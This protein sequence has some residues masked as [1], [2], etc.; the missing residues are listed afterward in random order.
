MIIIRQILDGLFLGL[1]AISGTYANAASLA[2]TITEIRV[3]IVAI[4]TFQ[5]TRRP[6]NEFRGTGFAVGDGKHIITNAH[7]IPDI[8]NTDQK[9]ILA[10]F[11]GSEIN[12]EVRSAAIVDMDIEHDLTLLKIDGKPLPSLQLGNSQRVR[13][14]EAV[15][16]TGFPIGMVL[17][18]YPITHR[19]IV[20]ALTPI[21]I[22][23]MSSRQLDA[24]TIKR[25]RKPYKVLQLDA[26]A[27]PGNS[28]S[29]VYDPASGRVIGIINKV[30]VK[31][32]KENLLTQPSGITYAIPSQYIRELLN[33]KGMGD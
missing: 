1:L 27:Y 31:E 33:R 12:I 23:A 29:P 2:D 32:S 13:E 10:V 3:S 20:S 8:L 25:L 17:G 18:L 15:A 24:T 16:F 21:A 22:P 9:E 28:G 19:G 11:A 6:P 4:G 7:V 30:F 5:A 26:T 14:G